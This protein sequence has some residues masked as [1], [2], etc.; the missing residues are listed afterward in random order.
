M[1]VHCDGVILLRQSVGETL[2]VE[3]WNPTRM[4]LRVSHPYL[5]EINARLE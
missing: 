5:K 2:K 3:D 4:K 1:D